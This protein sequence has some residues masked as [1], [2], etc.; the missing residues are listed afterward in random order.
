[1][2]SPVGT[3]PKAPVTIDAQGNPLR[4]G[5]QIV[6]GK[7]VPI[8]PTAKSGAE[9]KAAMDRVNADRGFVHKVMTERSRVAH[10]PTPSTGPRIV[11]GGGGIIWGGRLGRSW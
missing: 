3:P 7:I 9:T 5:A 10:E 4:P 2:R 8:P 6:D 11:E 1:M